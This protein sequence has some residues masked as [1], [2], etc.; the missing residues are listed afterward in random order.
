MVRSEYVGLI[1]VNALLCQTAGLAG[2][3]HCAA[4]RVKAWKWDPSRYSHGSRGT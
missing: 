4:I 2:F 1:I 3:P